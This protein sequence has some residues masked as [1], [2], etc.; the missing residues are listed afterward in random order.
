MNVQEFRS[1]LHDISQDSR[2]DEDEVLV[3]INGSLCLIKDVGSNSVNG[4]PTIYVGD[5]IE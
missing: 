3:E 1:W 5:A 4:K 2:N